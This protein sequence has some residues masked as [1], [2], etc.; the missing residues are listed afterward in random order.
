VDPRGLTFDPLQL[1]QPSDSPMPVLSSIT[2]GGSRVGKD[3]MFI[4]YDRN[5]GGPVPDVKWGKS[6]TV[7]GAGV[8]FA[9]EEPGRCPLPEEEPEITVGQSKYLGV[10]TAL[11][12]K[13]YGVNLGLGLGLPGLNVSAPSSAQEISEFTDPLAEVGF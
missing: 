8:S 12:A 6:T 13:R 2:I 11:D 3:F 10:F 1:Y 9:L 5:T 4:L 7:A